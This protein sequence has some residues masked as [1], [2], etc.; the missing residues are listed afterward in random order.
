MYKTLEESVPIGRADNDAAYSS[1]GLTTEELVGL[2]MGVPHAII[3]LA[4][5]ADVRTGLRAL[6]ALSFFDAGLPEPM[7]FASV[8]PDERAAM[9][10]VG[11][12]LTSQQVDEIT[13]VL[14]HRAN[15]LEIR[16]DPEDAEP[17]RLT[18]RAR[19]RIEFF[20]QVG[21]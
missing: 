9:L 1:G 8:T 4:E 17:E 15:S 5:F 16:F 7:V 14:L 6:H 20:G 18:R 19:S 10:Y 3:F 21:R 13:E 2:M 12:E 11:G